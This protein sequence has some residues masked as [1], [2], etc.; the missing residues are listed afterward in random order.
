MDWA[1]A[2]ARLIHFS[3]ALALVLSG[4][5]TEPMRD[6]TESER[7]DS[8]FVDQDPGVN[9]NQTTL[10]GMDEFDS[11]ESLDLDGC[12]GFELGVHLPTGMNSAPVPPGWEDSDPTD[13][14]T[15]NWLFAKCERVGIGELERPATILLEITNN[16][17]IPEACAE[18]AAGRVGGVIVQAWVND[19]GLAITLRNHLQWDVHE[20][21]FSQDVG[22]TGGV[23]IIN[24][25][26]SEGRVEA[27]HLPEDGDAG[28]PDWTVWWQTE[29]GI[30]RWDADVDLSRNSGSEIANVIPMESSYLRS[31]NDQ[32]PAA[33]DQTSKAQYNGE[34]T[35]YDSHSCS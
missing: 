20:A 7:S 16:G 32:V 24:A 34:I 22:T 25:N 13:L 6:A 19:T 15:I 14:T 30:G 33:F 29:N 1:V 4:C 5:T 10:E 9:G 21:E 2:A 35:W 12:S 17:N 28:F 18:G 27:I 31:V 11:I 26:Q 3:F 23:W 8:E